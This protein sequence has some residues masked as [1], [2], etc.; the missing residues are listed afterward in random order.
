MLRLFNFRTQPT[1]GAVI[2]FLMLLLMFARMTS[3]KVEVL[4]VIRVA[5]SINC[6]Y[7]EVIDF[8]SFELSFLRKFIFMSPRIKV[9][10]SDALT[11]FRKLSKSSLKC[12]GS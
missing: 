1:N 10:L 6:L 9:S 7:D 2:T 11:F 4:F 12:F 5:E 8:N 3:I